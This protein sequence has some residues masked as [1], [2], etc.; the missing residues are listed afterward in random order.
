MK[1]WHELPLPAPWRRLEA[2]ASTPST[3]DA[4][5]VSAG[6][7]SGVVLV[8]TAQTSGRGRLDR[9]WTSPPGAGL[10]FSALLR[11]QRPVADVGVVPLLSAVAIARTLNQ[12]WGLASRVKWPNDVLVNDAKIAGVLVQVVNSDCVVI[13]VGINTSMTH[14]QRPIATATSLA[15][16]G[17]VGFDHPQLLMSIL[18][19]LGEL[20][21][22][23]EKEGPWSSDVLAEYRALSSTVGREV[24]VHLPSGQTL[25]GLA[26]D[27][28]P[29]GRLEVQ[30]AD[31]VIV[32][33]GAGDVVHVR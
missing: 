12:D 14:E 5:V 24:S 3:Q 23:I 31:G 20:V 11:T 13:G 19:H 25:N 4:V 8:A 30:G 10:W 27:L 18:G 26:L 7:D 6:S 17:V 21:G 16:E 1:P 9:S 22:P 32:T 2:V 28:D 29:H 33:V 15:M